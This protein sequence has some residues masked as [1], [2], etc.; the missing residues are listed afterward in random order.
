MRFFP[1][2]IVLI[3]S[4]YL[5]PSV[6]NSQNR[7]D[8]IIPK[9]VSVEYTEQRAFK[10]PKRIT[11][12]TSDCQSES[13]YFKS[14]I[15]DSQGIEVRNVR[16]SRTA[17]ILM[18][19]A[20]EIVKKN[21][22]Y[23]L[24]VDKK[25]ITIIGH[26]NAGVFYGV[27]SLLQLFYASRESK[28]IESQ[29]ISDS[30]AFSWRAFM[31][32]EARH[33][34]GEK[35]VYR[36]LDEMAALKMNKI[37]WH[38]TDN[39]GWRIEIKKYPKLTEIGSIRKDTQMGDRKSEKTKGSPHSGFYTQADIKRILQYAKKRHIRIIPE[40]EMPGHASAAIA[41]Y[42]F[43]GSSDEKI[44]VPIKF[45]A[46]LAVFNVADQRVIHFLQ[47]VLDEVFT[48]FQT[49]II[50]IGGDEVRYNQWKV[51]KAINEWKDKNQL[52]SYK[53]FQVYFTNQM[54]KYIQSK[55]KRMMGWNEILGQGSEHK[56]N[57]VSSGNSNQRLADNVIVHFWQ[58]N[59]QKAIQAAKD[60]YDIV[61]SYRKFTY[62][63]YDYESISLEKAY[64]FSPIPEGMPKEFEYKILGVGCQLWTEWI[65]E[66]KKLNYQVFP[67]IAAIS[68]VGWTS[69]E[70]KDYT[71]F[72][73]RL[74]YFTDRWKRKNITYGTVV[75]E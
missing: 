68:E 6:S 50:H 70:R 21:E 28:V 19:V 18:S 20:P 23:K 43:L 25:K 29:V 53:D 13:D 51:N 45:G 38:L 64:S 35:E 62:L 46:H 15:Q 10:I 49:D 52:A 41:S 75:S 40:I 48:L 59:Q 69:N 26:D 32:D 72:L 4:L 42:P 9:P 3:I 56:D 66:P 55:G 17:D 37:H 39:E 54:S 74:K 8:V 27:Q 73:L 14:E 36:L 31:L 12:Y 16:K 58:G 67:R 44:E 33:F 30:P 60:G 63:D 22:G 61:N 5:F 7:R 65:D 24:I 34:Q 71:D 2:S 57:D 1:L 11:L 47:D